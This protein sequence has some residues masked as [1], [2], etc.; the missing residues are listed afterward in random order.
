MR[1]VVSC[2]FPPWTPLWASVRGGN[3]WQRKENLL[4]S[5]CQLSDILETVLIFSLCPSITLI[6]SVKS[7]MLFLPV[8]THTVLHRSTT[9]KTTLFPK[10]IPEAIYRIPNLHST[11]TYVELSISAVWLSLAIHLVCV[12]WVLAPPWSF[13]RFSGWRCGQIVGDRWRKP[14]TIKVA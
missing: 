7:H 2:L 5:D 13:D 6:S 4:L 10:W 3:Y 14:W 1:F 12:C 9:M 8:F 11:D